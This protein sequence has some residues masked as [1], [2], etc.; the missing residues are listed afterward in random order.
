MEDSQ[1]RPRTSYRKLTIRPA[2]LS[3]EYDVV[4]VGAGIGGL[5]CG[6]YLMKSGAKVLIVDRHWVPGGLCS[7]FKRKGFY[8]DAGAHYFGSIGDR[9]SFGGMLLRGLDLDVEFIRVD[10]VDI[11]HFPDETIEL[12][13]D[14]ELHIELLES[15]FPRERENIRAFFRE[16]LRIYRHF[17]R[18]KQKSEILERYRWCSYQEL[19]DR[20]FQD[21]KLKAILSATAPYI[22]TSANR[23][24]A[25]GM[26]SMIM[27]YFYDG[28][29]FGFE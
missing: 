6:A 29:L 2:Q 21:A 18:G 17:Y 23:V 5:I 3:T 16:T 27:S 4:V 26:A 15:R 11:L 10:P 19:L 9:K 8:F 24:S 1:Q 28:G 22:G 7:F 13:A 12:P 14:F 20:Y 25:I